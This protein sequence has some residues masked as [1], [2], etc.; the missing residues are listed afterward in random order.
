MHTPALLLGSL[1]MVLDLMVL[2]LALL[3]AR[4]RSLSGG[5]SRE[6]GYFCRDQARASGVPPWMCFDSKRRR[7]GTSVGS[8]CDHLFVQES[9]HPGPGVSPRRRDPVVGRPRYSAS[10]SYSSPPLEAA[11]G[12]THLS[13]RVSKAISCF[14][15]YRHRRP[16]GLKVAEDGSL[17]VNQVWLHW[18]RP[19]V[20]SRQQLLQCIT[21]LAFGREGRRR[22]HR[23]RVASASGEATVIL[24]DSPLLD[25]QTDAAPVCEPPRPMKTEGD[26]NTLPVSEALVSD[27]NVKTEDSVPLSEPP[28]T[29]DVSGTI[30][31]DPDEVPD[32]TK[33]RDGAGDLKVESDGDPD[34]QDVNSHPVSDDESAHDSIAPT[35]VDTADVPL[36]HNPGEAS[37]P[38]EVSVVSALPLWPLAVPSFAFP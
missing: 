34:W 7:L 15:R 32:P 31:T 30:K 37:F 29:R 33:T 36:A 27:C 1:A 26:D 9:V 22:R 24:C 23:R 11:A 10:R 28:V 17:D 14:A 19:Q 8:S 25:T 38:A 12:R 4:P 18:G 35:V 3:P 16:A 2:P 13:L 21:T 6:R 20:I 5:F